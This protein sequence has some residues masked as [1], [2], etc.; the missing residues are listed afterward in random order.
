MIAGAVRHMMLPI[1]SA[2]S[3]RIF[4]SLTITNSVVCP[5]PPDGATIPA[6]TMRRRCSSGTGSF[7]YF[8]R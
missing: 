8:S 7:R 3:S 2:R 6:V 5:F 4:G 1:I